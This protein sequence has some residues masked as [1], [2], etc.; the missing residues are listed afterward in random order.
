MCE[1]VCVC[2]LNDNGE[3]FQEDLQQANICYDEAQCRMNPGMRVLTKYKG[4]PLK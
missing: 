3:M 4:Y 1:C 2:P